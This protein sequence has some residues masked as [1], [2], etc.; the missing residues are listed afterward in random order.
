MDFPPWPSSSVRSA[1]FFQEDWTR[2]AL[3]TSETQQ[4]RQRLFNKA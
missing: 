2:K 3:R 1:G 4:A